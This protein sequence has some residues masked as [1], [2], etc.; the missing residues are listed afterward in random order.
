MPS[1]DL[2]FLSALYEARGF[3][4]RLMLSVECMTCTTKRKLEL[5]MVF[6]TTSTA[7][8]SLTLVLAYRTKWHG[9]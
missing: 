9:D 1:L 6:I 4:L 8:P 2:V 3:A 7:I 5:R